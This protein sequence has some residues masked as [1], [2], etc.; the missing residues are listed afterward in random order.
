[1]QKIKLI[2]FKRIFIKMIIKLCHFVFYKYY[3]INQLI[4]VNDI[5]REQEKFL[6]A[7]FYSEL[8]IENYPNNWNGYVRASQDYISLGM[9]ENAKLICQKAFKKLPNYL[10]L[11]CATNDVY[12]AL[13]EYDNALTYSK[14]MLSEY[15]SDWNG[16]VRA[17]R[18]LISLGFFDKSMSKSYFL[19]SKNIIHIGIDRIPDNLYLL[20][21][22]DDV[23]RI[24]GQYEK[25]IN[26]SRA[27]IELYSNITEG[28]IR[29]TS[30][31]ISMK[32][33]KEAEQTI[34]DGLIINSEDIKL[35]KLN[36]YISTFTLAEHIIDKK[37]LVYADL[38]YQDLISYSHLDEYFSILSNKRKKSN[39]N[40]THYKQLLFVSGMARS[41]T[42][43]VGTL[44]NISSKVEIYTELFDPF[45]INGYVVNDFITNVL[46]N[47]IYKNEERDINLP[48]FNSK[49]SNS[50]YIG[51]K[52]PDFHFCLEA[53]YDNFKSNVRTVFIVRN[54][55]SIARSSHIRSEDK[56]DFTWSLEKGIEHTIL[57]YNATCRQILFLHRRRIDV[58]NSIIF[59]DYK[60]IFSNIDYSIKLFEKLNINLSCI[61]INHLEQF[62]FKSSKK[63][64][65]PEPLDK[66]HYKIKKLISLYID[67]Q[68]HLSFCRVTGIRDTIL[69]VED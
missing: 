67:K 54:L 58:F 27:I 12:R 23:Y 64:L 14:L 13:K 5:A 29:L 25:S 22:A 26:Y 59:I 34:K 19:K 8:I 3:D 52:R 57:L 43:A 38:N 65:K 68:A 53:T 39:K 28:Y 50:I 62:I 6:K 30:N 55:Y 7:L 31:L 63:G 15:P 46:K 24:L 10:V 69:N 9:F 17:S 51:D 18:D 61:E 1:M 2:T 40:K 35:K 36:S 47:S 41:G 4:K 49:H 33:F 11:L 21:M 42:T 37:E 48:L 16:Y 56:N 32:L 20:C 44:L 66:L 60:H 45:R